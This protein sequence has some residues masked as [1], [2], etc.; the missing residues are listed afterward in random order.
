MSRTKVI[1][2]F[3]F[4]KEKGNYSDIKIFWLSL[5]CTPI[6]HIGLNICQKIQ[7]NP[8]SWKKVYWF[9]NFWQK[10]GNNCGIKLF[11]LS[12]F[13]WTHHT[14]W[15]KHLSEVSIQ[16][17]E[18]KKKLIDFI[19]NFIDRKR[20][21]IVIKTYLDYPFFGPITPIDIN[22]CQKFQSN[23]L[24]Q[25]RDNYSDLKIDESSPF[26]EPITSLI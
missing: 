19:L 12:P 17:F 3:T 20:A 5:F 26:C 21:I 16:S 9:F 4:F 18:L 23:P 8:W 2:K 14:Y 7:S 10:R 11:G 24:G 1:W 22:I 6:T 25:R 13:F 15:Y